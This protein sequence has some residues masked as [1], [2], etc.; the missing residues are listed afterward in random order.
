[1]TGAQHSTG[2]RDSAGAHGSAG[3]HDSAGVPFGGRELTGTGFDG[4]TGEVDARLAAALLDPRAESELV[5]AVA[6]ARLVVPVVAEPTEVEESAGQVVEK[7]TDMAVVTL[8]A[9]DGTRALPVFSGVASLAAWDDSARPVPVTAARA[10]Q[11]AVAERCDVMVVDIAG[12]STVALR[13]SM[14]WA[15][16]QQRDWVPAHEDESV[17]RAVALAVRDLPEVVAHE[18]SAGEPGQGVLRVGLELVPGLTA[19]QVQ[20]VATAVGERLATDGEVR[21]RIDALS[22]SIH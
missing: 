9:P 22:F 2:A 21:A 15:L 1:M 14:V 5:A 6:Q 19:D 11:A 4:D 16:A 17:R 7:R 20:Q 8:V 18:V 13:P 10:A 12:P 3:A